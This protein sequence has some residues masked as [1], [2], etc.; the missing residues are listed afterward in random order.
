MICFRANGTVMKWVITTIASP[1]KI[2][3]ARLTKSTFPVDVYQNDTLAKVQKKLK[4]TK[5][6]KRF[7]ANHCH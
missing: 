1:A 7:G 6:G 4:I 2:S 5:Q 3:L